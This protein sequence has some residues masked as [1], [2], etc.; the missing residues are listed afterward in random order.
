MDECSDTPCAADALCTNTV[1]SYSCT[2]QPGYGGDPYGKA[3]EDIDE[4][5]VH[6]PCHSNATCENRPGSYSCTCNVHYTGSGK[7]C[8]DIDECATGNHSCTQPNV[9]CVNENDGYRCACLPGYAGNASVGCQDVDEC[10]AAPCTSN[11]TCTNT[12]GS[13][14]CQCQPG[15]HGNA[16][17]Q[18]LPWSACGPAEYELV[19]PTAT[20]DRRCASLT[21]CQ[22]GYFV[23]RAATALADRT[24]RAC[25]HSTFTPTANLPTCHPWAD[26]VVGTSYRCGGRNATADT[27]CCPTTDCTGADELLPASLTADRICFCRSGVVCVGASVH[28]TCAP[29]SFVNAT[30]G[31]SCLACMPG[32]YTAAANH[33]ACQAYNSSCPAGYESNGTSPAK[34][35]L[36]RRCLG[37]FSP[38]GSPCV[39]FTDCT[40]PNTTVLFAGNTTHDRTCRSCDGPCVLATSTSSA[41]TPVALIAGVAA[42]LVL[43]VLLLVVARQR[44]R[45]RRTA[46]LR[47]D[48]AKHLQARNTGITNF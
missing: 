18:C 19:A 25:N 34:G 44:H 33:L 11:A 28:A 38:D 40:G 47:T 10:A 30:A 8:T 29:G 3:C 46:D 45:R 5:A 17:K 20:T 39:A 24:C 6:Q 16:S 1:G 7:T 21:E 42:G 32:T 36:C 31:H 37:S 35:R 14:V 13:F 27:M 9:G 12:P 4:C 15:L 2:C 22:P 41:A 48:Y 43:L 23:Q 26:C